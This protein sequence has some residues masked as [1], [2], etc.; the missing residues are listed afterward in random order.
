LFVN[1]KLEERN[2]KLIKNFRFYLISSQNS[3]GFARI[4]R[5]REGEK[6]KT[7]NNK[8]TVSSGNFLEDR[9]F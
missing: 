1:L 4:L 6:R 5:E 2:K 9:E 8:K 7:N 3:L